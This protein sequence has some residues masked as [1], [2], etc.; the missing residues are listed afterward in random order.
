VADQDG[1]GLATETINAIG[2]N[3]AQVSG[4]IVELAD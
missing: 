1:L 4:T 2:E 3:A